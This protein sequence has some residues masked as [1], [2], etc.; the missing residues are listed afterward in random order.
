MFES[1]W[2]PNNFMLVSICCRSLVP[3]LHKSVWDETGVKL[4]LGVGA[5]LLHVASGLGLKCLRL[6][7]GPNNFMLVSMYVDE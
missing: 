1:A 7:G 5:G 3:R 6:R 4:K 2:G